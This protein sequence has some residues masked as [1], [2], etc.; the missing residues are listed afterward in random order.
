M[1]YHSE[2]DTDL[3]EDLSVRQLLELLLDE[4]AR[5]RLMLKQ[6]SNDEIFFLYFQELKLRLTPGQYEEYTRVLSKF[7]EYLGSWPPTSQL[8]VSFLAQFNGHQAAVIRYHTMVK[9]FMYWLGEDMTVKVRRPKRLPQYVEPSHV[10]QL[11]DAIRS[12]RTHKDTTARDVILI[13]IARYTGLRRAELANIKVG[14]VLLNERTLL[15]RGGKGEK[16]AA[17]PL[18]ASL[19]P[20][21]QEFLKGKSPQD[22]VFGLTKASVSNKIHNWAKKAGVPLHAHSLRHYYAERL[23]ES[24]TDLRVVQSL[25]RHTRLDTTGQ[26]L[27]LKPNALREAVDRLDDH[28]PQP[29]IA[30]PHRFAWERPGV[31]AKKKAAE[32]LPKPEPFFESHPELADLYNKSY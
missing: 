22:S 28:K 16:D 13:E 27:G 18:P 19:I 1:R 29:K 21:L 24:G 7:R 6:K 3:S 26:Y 17:V 11:I 2:K 25:L 14:D 32:N 30:E 8:A 12:K 20:R 31:K 9:G 10:E 5:R 4:R 15:V 23:L